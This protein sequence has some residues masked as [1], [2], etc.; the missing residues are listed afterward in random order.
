MTRASVGEFDSLIK[1]QL[2][3]KGWMM[4]ANFRIYKGQFMTRIC[5][6]LEDMTRTRV[7]LEEAFPHYMRD[8]VPMGDYISDEKMA[9]CFYRGRVAI[10]WCLPRRIRSSPRW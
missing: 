8:A 4:G 10:L 7:E 5:P 2:D 1:A 6:L 9:F 3:Y